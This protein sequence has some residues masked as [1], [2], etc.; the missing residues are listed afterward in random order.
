LPKEHQR[1]R[2]ASRIAAVLSS[3][4]RHLPFLARTLE[5]AR[6]ASVFP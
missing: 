1:D 2:A 6:V 4:R 5:P 3:R